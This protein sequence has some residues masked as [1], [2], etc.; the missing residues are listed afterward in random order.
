MLGYLVNFCNEVPLQTRLLGSNSG[1]TWTTCDGNNHVGVFGR[2]RKLLWP[3]SAEEEAVYKCLS[4]RRFV[5]LRAARGDVVSDFRLSQSR[6]NH[7]HA[8]EGIQSKGRQ[9][10]PKTHVDGIHKN[11]NISFVQSV[12]EA[13]RVPPNRRPK[14]ADSLNLY[15]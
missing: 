3:P 15:S 6:L 13:I 10:Y 12:V 4:G 1:I 11:I 7:A 2:D 8:K 9:M 5:T 14:S